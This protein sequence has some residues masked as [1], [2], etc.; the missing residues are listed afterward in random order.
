MRHCVWLLV[1]VFAGSVSGGAGAV[2]DE[3]FLQDVAVR[4]ET[5][6]ELGQP[7]FR[8][9]C[10]DKEGVPYVLSD[11]G[12]ARV[13]DHALA[14]DHSFRPLAGQLP[15][16]IAVSPQGDLYY[17][18]EDRWLSNGRT[19]EPLGHFPPGSFDTIA[20]ADD[21][22]VWLSGKG[23]L[24][25]MRGNQI[26]Y[27]STSASGSAWIIQPAGLEAMPALA[28][29]G[30]LKWKNSAHLSG[31]TALARR[32]DGEI[33]VGTHDGYLGID[34]MDGHETTTRQTKL[35]WTDITRIFPVADGVWF[36]TTRGAFFQ[37]SRPAE[38]PALPE[39]VNGVRYYAS[40]RW[41]KDDVVVD[42]AIDPEGSL[43]VLT[44]TGLN[45]I[46]FRSM[47]L[48]QKAAHFDK[49]IRQ[50]HIRYG[51]SA[52]RRLPVSGD[53]ASSEMIDTDNDGGWSSYYLA[54]QAFRYAATGSREARRNAWE[55]FYA[56][57]RL[58]TINSLPGF[59]SRTIER[60]GFK[61]SDPDRWRE[62][63]GGD[64]DWKGHTS[65][66]EICS[67]TLAH[68]VMWECVAKTAEERA[69]VAT[70]YTRMVD[71]IIRNNWY[72]VDVDGKPTLWG[73][74]NPEYVNWY[75]P[76]I[77]DRRLN[78]AEITASLQL[79]YAMTGNKTY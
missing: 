53:I 14:P 35:P 40:R 41:L 21:G 13:F 37:R 77:V 44:K 66:D 38:G 78:S 25:R 29:D 11:K 19:G 49:K 24:A 79:A 16:D 23:R 69:R 52:E 45:K 1:L 18:F 57:E 51:L 67:Q 4:I 68:A 65:S 39:G 5:A 48:A 30:Q 10:V 27:P 20:V 64:W 2:K 17:L 62:V 32:G 43:W 56:L 22:T 73:R 71:H 59:S 34:R 54:S 31:V 75:P 42:L 12:M 74:W 28:V 72:Y 3:P 46:E 26:D 6:K 70:N 76:S 58:Q 55:V 50:R 61:F 60:H 36:G 8:K 63:P 15:K 7:V 33:L 9:L 47:T